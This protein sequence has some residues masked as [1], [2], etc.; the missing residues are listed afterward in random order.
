MCFTSGPEKMKFDVARL[1]PL[2][3][4]WHV[5]TYEYSPDHTNWEQGVVDYKNLP[6]AG[7]VEMWDDHAPAGYSYDAA[8][9]VMNTYDTPRAVEAKCDYVKQKGLGGLIMWESKKTPRL[10]ITDLGSGDAPYSSDRSLLKV[11]HD[12]LLSENTGNPGTGNPGSVNPGG[13]GTGNP[14]SGNPSTG[15]PPPGVHP[16]DPTKYYPL[17]TLVTYNGKTY[18]CTIAHQA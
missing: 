14:G 7:A 12:N 17:G 1:I 6:I 10:D 11:I 13:P 4:Q 16:W 3:D 5:M 2:L 18:K 8:R 15:P 9:K